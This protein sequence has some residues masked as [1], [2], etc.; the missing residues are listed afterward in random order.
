MFNEV[1]TNEIFLPEI[2]FSSKTISRP[3]RFSLLFFQEEIIYLALLFPAYD[4][5]FTGG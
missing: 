4:I 3:K 2:C 5:Q 1:K